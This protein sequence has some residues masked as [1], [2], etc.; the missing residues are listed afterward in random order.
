MPDKS[1][2]TG[3][4][5]NAARHPE[6][7]NP[8]SRRAEA[9][10]AAAR[11][12]RESS[13]I[14]DCFSAETPRLHT[15]EIIRRTGVPPSILTEMLRTLVEENLLQREGV[16]YSVALRVFRWSASADAASDLM[17]AARPSV[18]ALRDRTGECCGLQVR[19]GGDHLTVV[20]KN[21]MHTVAHH[22]YVGQMKPLHG[23]AAG[24]V[25]MAY[26]P[27]ALSLVLDEGL[28]A[29]TPMT[30]IEPATLQRQLEQVRMQGWTFS[31][32]EQEL[33]LNTL[34]A[35]VYAADGNVAAAVTLGGPA[36]RLTPARVEDLAGPVTE[37]ALGISR[38]LATSMIAD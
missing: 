20:W 13:K 7:A 3:F 11:I 37:C 23:S 18:T 30:V 35:P 32:E 34:A 21:C 6:G 25:F 33:G 19:R 14:L 29:F 24:K 5:T 1:T 26:E 15:S 10:T 38:F 4:S 2:A 17:T 16:F 9:G 8:T 31:G 28:T 12:L 27:S 22:G 36:H